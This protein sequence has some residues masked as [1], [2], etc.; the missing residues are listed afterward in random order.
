ML[1]IDIVSSAIE[2]YTERFD[3]GKTAF[4]PSRNLQ[5][6]Y[7]NQFD[8]SIRHLYKRKI[9]E[10]DNMIVAMNTDRDYKSEGY[11]WVLCDYNFNNKKIRIFNSSP[12]CNITDEVL[13]L[14]KNV[15]IVVNVANNSPVVLE[16]YLLEEVKNTPI[17]ENLECGICV[18][19]NAKSVIMQKK[20]HSE[21][22]DYGNLRKKLKT[23][24]ENFEFPIQKF[25]NISNDV[26]AKLKSKCV[27]YRKIY[28]K[29]KLT[30]QQEVYY[31]KIYSTMFNKKWNIKCN[32][33][34]I[35]PQIWR[36]IKDELIMIQCNHC[37]RWFHIDCV[38]IKPYLL[39]NTFSCDDCRKLDRTLHI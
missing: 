31:P 30:T 22:V 15:I 26:L 6:L 24:L 7:N 33:K 4:F 13:N 23:E 9:L 39:D 19:E 37:R 14:I 20:L 35:I 28:N 34:C 16:N 25:N 5:G 3:N 11:H 21:K 8:V 38:N 10:K 12:E 18:V 2:M 29:F 32:D 1:D 36:Q 27:K 17:Q